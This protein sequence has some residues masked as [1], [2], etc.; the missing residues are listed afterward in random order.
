M[1][2][3]TSFP[4]LERRLRRNNYKPYYI[5]DDEDAI[6]SE[7]CPTCGISLNYMG[8]KKQYYYRA[9]MYCGSCRYWEEYL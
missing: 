3:W 5:E 2:Q 1:F 6:T 9:F 4:D 7:I 8:Y